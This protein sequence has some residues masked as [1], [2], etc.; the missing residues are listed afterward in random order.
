VGFRISAVVIPVGFAIIAL[1]HARFPFKLRILLLAALGGVLLVLR[2]TSLTAPIVVLASLFMLRVIVYLYDLKN[3]TAPFSF[4]RATS[5]FFMLPNVC[6][7][8]FPLVDYKT[9]CTTHY[10][11]APLAIY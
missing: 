3:R 9:F 7:P 4:A 1:C 11:D 5:Y 10:N 6:F 8:L 2:I